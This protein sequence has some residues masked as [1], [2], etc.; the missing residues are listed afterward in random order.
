[1]TMAWDDTQT[2][3]TDITHGE[4]N[5]MVTNIKQRNSIPALIVASSTAS[6]DVLANADYVCDGT[7]DDVQIQAAITASTGKVILSEGVFNIA[8]SITVNKHIIIEGT[9]PEATEVKAAASLNAYIF[10][11]NSTNSA[12]QYRVQFRNFKIDGNEDNSTGGGVLSYGAIQ[13]TFEKMH[14]EY[15]YDWGVYLYDTGGGSGSYGHHNQI[16]DCLFDQGEGSAGVGGGV[17]MRNCDENT[18]IGSQFQ[19]LKLGI[20]DETGFNQIF[21]CSFVDGLTGIYVLDASRTRITNCIF[22]YCA[23]FGIDLKGPF[24]TV[25]ACTFYRCSDGNNNGYACLYI[26]WYGSNIIT[27][28]MFLA[29]DTTNKTKA[30]IQEAG[31]AAEDTYDYNIIANNYFISIN[32]ATSLQGSSNWGT[33]ALIEASSNN[34]KSNNTTRV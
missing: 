27:D 23:N 8:A 25:N 11:V 26:E 32:G 12:T 15:C 3:G 10:I 18:V 2:T 31:N 29:E 24:N 34:V 33:A 5:T 7:A 6:A 28:N 21:G 9:G 1:M 14:F 30:A 4:W 19:Y 16:I 17:Y 13:S 22:D 20:K